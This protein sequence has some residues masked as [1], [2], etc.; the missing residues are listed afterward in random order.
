VNIQEMAHQAAEGPFKD[1]IIKAS[2]LVGGSTF[3]S[4]FLIEPSY[5]TAWGQFMGGLA[6]LITAFYMIYKGKAK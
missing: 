3:F 5:L 4:G 1:T 6:A 2:G